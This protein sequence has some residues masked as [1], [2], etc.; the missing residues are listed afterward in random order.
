MQVYSNH[1]L[2]KPY[3][4]EIIEAKTQRR[5]YNLGSFPGIKRGD[6]QVIGELIIIDQDYQQEILDRLDTL[7]GHLDFYHREK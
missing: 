2:V 4:T 3:L 1:S 6:G 5:L 7:E